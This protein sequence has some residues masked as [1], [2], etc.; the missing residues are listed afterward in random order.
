[1]FTRPTGYLHFR[2][3]AYEAGLV[4]ANEQ[5]LAEMKGRS[6]EKRID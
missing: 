6:V 3:Y 1:M 2:F 4:L 5:Q